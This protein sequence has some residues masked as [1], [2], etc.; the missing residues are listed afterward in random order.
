MHL[1][2][3]VLYAE[4]TP[5]SLAEALK[6]CLKL[7]HEEREEMIYRGREWLKV[8]CNSEEYSRKLLDILDMTVKKYERK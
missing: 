1:K 3:G 6:V 4:Q 5:E 2:G 8:N 7:S